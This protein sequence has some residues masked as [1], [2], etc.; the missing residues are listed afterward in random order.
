MS[1]VTS[2]HRKTGRVKGRQA[3]LEH[4]P[5]RSV[6]MASASVMILA[7][8]ALFL[9]GSSASARISFH[10]SSYVT[11]NHDIIVYGDI[12]NTSGHAAR[13]AE[14][15]ASWFSDHHEG[16]VSTTTNRAGLYRLVLRDQRRTEVVLRVTDFSSGRFYEGEVSFAARKGRAYDASGEL[17][18]R[19]VLLFF[20]VGSY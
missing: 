8:M 19:S 15:R 10:L 4:R 2:S 13:G 5:L 6:L 14:V 1:T 3:R 11:A 20:P 18:G 12:T 7:V 17:K 16:R 9:V